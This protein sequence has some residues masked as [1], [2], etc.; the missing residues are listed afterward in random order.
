MSIVSE[1]RTVVDEV[2]AVFWPDQQVYDAVNESQI[3]QQLTPGLEV[4]SLDFTVGAADGL[5]SIP[6]E[7]MVPLRIVKKDDNEPC[8]ITTQVKLEQHNQEWRK[9]EG[10]TPRWFVVWDL[11]HFRPYPKANATYTYTLSYI[12]YPAVEIAVGTEDISAATPDLL[13]NAIVHQSAA[14]LLVATMPQFALAQLE[15]AKGYEERFRR[16]LRNQQ[17]HKIYKFRPGGRAARAESGVVRPVQW[18]V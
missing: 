17:S 9:G 15:E 14:R 5:I 4:A 2:A 1:V 10:G 8:W 18:F 16:R 3:V 12:P 6:T 7:V 13:R 11:S